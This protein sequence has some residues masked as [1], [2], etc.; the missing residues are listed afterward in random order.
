MMEEAA[1]DA[2]VVVAVFRRLEAEVEVPEGQEGRKGMLMT[3]MTATLVTMSKGVKVARH[4]NGKAIDRDKRHGTT[5]HEQ[6]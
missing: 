5:A 6:D 4:V 1:V 2:E 3:M